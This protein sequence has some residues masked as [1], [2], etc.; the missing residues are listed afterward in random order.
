M[1]A[2]FLPRLMRA[3]TRW[4]LRACDA[5]GKDPAL[6]GRPTVDNQGQMHVGA[7]FRLASCPV[8]SHMVSGPRGRLAI[9]DDV[10]IAHG[11]ALAAYSRV[12]IGDG[13][14]IGPFVIVMDTDFHVSGDRGASA[15]AAPITV[16]RRVLIGS[17][18]TILRGSVIEDGAFIAAGS[19]VSGLIPAGARAAGVPARVVTA[20]TDPAESAVSSASVP[21]VLMRTFVLLCPPAPED[22]PS[23]ISQWDSLGT[24]SLLLALEEEF[25]VRLS[26]EEMVRVRSVADLG[27]M[28]E[29]AQAPAP[30]RSLESSGGYSG[31]P[32]DASAI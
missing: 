11:A 15:E 4:W 17:R 18:V 28:V 1:S 19:V 16:G 13:T 6:E 31:H 10:A 32:G 27:A 12:Q 21:E 9:G 25:G 26:E 14:R 22:G 7:R 30:P 3:R 23:Q 5:L 20:V 2:R 8:G 24:L 29:R